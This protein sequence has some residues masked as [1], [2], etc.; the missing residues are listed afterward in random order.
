MKF[1]QTVS[2][3]LILALSSCRLWRPDADHRS[4]RSGERP[5]PDNVPAPDPGTSPADIPASDP[6]E[7]AAPKGPILLD[8]QAARDR[9]SL[10]EVKNRLKFPA[11][12]TAM[13]TDA[14]QKKAAPHPRILANREDF[15]RIRQAL[16]AQ[17]PYVV[18]NVESLKKAAEKYLKDAVLPY[19]FDEAKL[20][21]TA[22]H[23]TQEAIA[24]L[25]LLY[26]LTG[27]RTYAN[28]VKE[29]LLNY[30]NFPDWNDAKHFLDTGIMSYSVALA[31]DW[32]YDNLNAEERR[33]IS[34]ALMEK[35]MKRYLDRAAPSAF[36][37]QSKNNWNPICNGGVS[38]A[39]M[40]VMDSSAEAKKLGAEVLS[41]ALQAVP[42]YIREFEPDGQTVEGM[43][44]WDYGLSNLI[45]WMETLRRSLGTDYGYTDTMGLRVAGSFPLAV[46]GPVTGIS[47]GDDPL[48]TSRSGTNFWF[49]KRYNSPSL[50]RY[51]QEEIK[52]YQKY[53]WMDLLFYDPKLL[54]NTAFQALPLD[55][56]VRDL[57]FVSFRSSWNHA[58][59]LYVAIHG[60]DNNASHGH[61]DA[62]TFFVQGAGQ[63]W[64][65]G[66]LGRDNYTF[67]GYFSKQTLPDYMSS[68][69][70]V[71]E[72][73]RF[74][75]YRLRA[76][77]K[78][79]LVL[80]PDVR[81]DQ[82]PQGKAEVERILSQ[83]TDA[84]AILNLSAVYDRDAHIVRRGIGLRQQRQVVVIQDEIKM[85]APGTVWWSMHTSAAVELQQNGRIAVL[86]SGGKSLWMEIQS[87]ASAAFTIRDAE[88][89]PGLSFPGSK[90]TANTFQGEVVKKLTITLQKVSEANITVGMKL[91]QDMRDI[92]MLPAPARLDD[93]AKAFPM[94]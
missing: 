40:A 30:A 64:A 82:N 11:V 94:P 38:L 89:I 2:L 24:V 51:H 37:Y 68:S 28:K 34:T 43:M 61:L 14:F 72:P 70:T 21:L 19:E 15:A 31:Y 55:R 49:A 1:S 25:S 48:K 5:R 27:N 86:R 9:I 87:P 44:Y 10:D 92:P 36:W 12:T 57:E 69:R 62:G 58:Q 23:A 75:M 93:W 8:Y 52:L 35:G 16:S 13:I 50:A 90:D 22:P 83:A 80:N 65:I 67:P 53:T 77:G 81:P 32:T 20:R 63:V 18:A 73:G 17:D 6:L 59:S 4:V 76:E 54:Q 26:Q 56:Y 42:S 33:I 84:M 85:K 29:H 39:A 41:R 7:P 88:H 3:I 60:G 47:V 74:H 79:T 91:I 66:G 45:R 46:S 71:S 78:N